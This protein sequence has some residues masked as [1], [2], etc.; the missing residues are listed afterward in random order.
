MS[1]FNRSIGILF[2]MGLSII[3]FA[4]CSSVMLNSNPPQAGVWDQSGSFVGTTPVNLSAFFS[5]PI[6]TG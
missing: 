6:P 3:L 2:A 5:H 4:G 1:G